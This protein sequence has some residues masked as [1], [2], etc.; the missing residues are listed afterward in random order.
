MEHQSNSKHKT[1]SDHD[2]SPE[3][4]PTT[5]KKYEIIND[6][7]SPVYPPIIPTKLQLSTNR[8]E[9]SYTHTFFRSILFQI[10]IKFFVCASN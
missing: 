6:L 1:P 7:S 2:K 4:P 10:T 5:K 9:N 3:T 8:D